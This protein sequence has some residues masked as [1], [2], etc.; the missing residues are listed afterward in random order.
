MNK[1]LNILNELAADNSRLAKEA[2]LKR[3]KDNQLLKEVIVAALDPYINYYQKKIPEYEAG[4][5]FPGLALSEALNELKRLSR[6]EV[7]G[8]T[9]INT[10]GWI[11]QNCSE[12]DAA[13][14][15]RV[16]S[17]D[18]KCGVSESTVNKIWPGL[19][20]TFDV[21]TCHKDISGI[22]YP[23]FAQTKMDGARCHLFFDGKTAQAFA[24]SGKQFHLHGALDAAASIMMEAGETFDGELL[25]VDKNG[26]ILDRKTSNG[27]ANK[28]NKG[29]ISEEEAARVVFVAWDIV[30]FTSKIPYSERLTKLNQ[31][32]ASAFLAQFKTNIRMV[33]SVVVNNVE[34]ALA[35]YDQERADGQE[36]AILKNMSTLWVAKR[37]KDQGKMKAE[38]EADLIVVGFNWGNGKYEGKLGSLI[39]QTRDGKLEV[40]VSGMPE[41]IRFSRKPED[42][43]GSIVTVRYNEVI[44]NRNSDTYAL[45]LPRFIEER[46]DKKV[47]NSFEELK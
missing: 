11:L 26:K 34:E 13:V 24:R 22:K 25:F 19:I 40:S 44:K 12:A 28:A 18:L 21:M 17:R 43:V 5:C 16:I 42:W 6:R 46:F 10:L 30:D 38:E 47:A 39:C 15:E 20:P 45:F 35:F 8:Q 29:T 33:K 27:I 32:F 14:I 23:A 41:D 36:G 1:I 2:I 31:R 9:A 37:S 3:E 7:T 4:K